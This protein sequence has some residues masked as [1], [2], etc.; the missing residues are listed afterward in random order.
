M[1][2]WAITCLL[3]RWHLSRRAGCTTVQAPT[4][5]TLTTILIHRLGETQSLPSLATPS[6]TPVPALGSALGATQGT[7]F[8]ATFGTTVLR[9]ASGSSACT[10]RN[11]S[12]YFRLT[13][14]WWLDAEVPVVLV[15]RS[16]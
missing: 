2:A 8:E 12:I 9:P 11:P 10:L 15:P 14:C 5:S 6:R 3:V 1:P 7:P 16:C 4:S 13:A